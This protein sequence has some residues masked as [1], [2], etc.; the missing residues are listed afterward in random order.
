MLAI[1]YLAWLFTE[2]SGLKLPPALKMISYLLFF[3]LDGSRTTLTSG[4]TTFFALSFALLALVLQDH[5]RDTLAGIALGLALSKYH[6]ALP[7]MLLVLLQ[8]N[9][10]TFFVAALVQIAGILVLAALTLSS[11]INIVVD[12]AK[13][14]SFNATLANAKATGVHLAAYLPPNFMFDVGVAILLT[15]GLLVLTIPPF[16]AQI[17]MFLSEASTTAQRHNKRMIEIHVLA[18]LMSWLLL[19]VYHLKY[20]AGM[21]IISIYLIMLAF[22]NSDRWALPRTGVT[23]LTSLLLI[24][25]LLLIYAFPVW[26]VFFPAFP[27]ELVMLS[28]TVS[29]LI[30]LGS[31]I[32]LFRR[33][34][35]SDESDQRSG[36]VA[37]DLGVP[38]SVP[39]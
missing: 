6:V 8:R 26:A 32:V 20:D 11:P 23:I 4:Q 15:L 24:S 25:L 2:R 16:V 38:S 37:A 29:I 3:S 27:L 34:Q 21:T 35:L 9:F 28:Q 17:K 7:V 18:I 19:A 5:R 22:L 31:S 33:L 39:G 1:P 36:N 12:Y 13:M 10:K 30:L 14:A